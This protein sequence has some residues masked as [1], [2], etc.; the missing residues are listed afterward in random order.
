VVLTHLRGQFY[1]EEVITWQ[2]YVTEHGLF[3]IKLHKLQ[4]KIGCFHKNKI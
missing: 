4:L 2:C 1:G 3:N